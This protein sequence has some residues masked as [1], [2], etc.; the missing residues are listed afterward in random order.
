MDWFDRDPPIPRG[1]RSR[2][3][4]TGV[5]FYHLSFRSG[6]RSGG[7]CAGAAHAYITRTEEYDDPE[8]DALP[9]KVVLAEF[10]EHRM[11]TMTVAER[12]QLD[13][14]MNWKTAR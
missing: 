2:D 10:V 13:S 11:L 9:S 4:A 14:L 7:A 6:S 8:R 12:R 3:A 1:G 5:S